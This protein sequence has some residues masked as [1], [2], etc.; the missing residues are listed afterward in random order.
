MENIK[1]AHTTQY[2]RNKQPSQEGGRKPKQT[3]LRRRLTGGQ[4]A[5][6]KCSVRLII[7]ET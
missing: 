6:E 4:Q 1:R 2:Q 7:R 3:F 5:H